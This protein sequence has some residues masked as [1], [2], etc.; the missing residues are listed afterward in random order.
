MRRAEP[1]CRNLFDAKL[2]IFCFVDFLISTFDITFAINRLLCYLFRKCFAMFL[3]FTSAGTKKSLCEA[4]TSHL[5]SLF[6][7]LASPQLIRHTAGPLLYIVGKRVTLFPKM[8]PSLDTYQPV[9]MTNVN[10][11]KYS[12]KI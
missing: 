4:H 1:V 9:Q 6:Q 3:I 12:F 11:F 5:F 2:N 7:E 10:N 8:V